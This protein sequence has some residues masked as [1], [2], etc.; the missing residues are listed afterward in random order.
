MGG[1]FYLKKNICWKLLFLFVSQ[2]NQN[3]TKGFLQLKIKPWQRVLLTRS[4][5]I[6]PAVLVSLVIKIYV[7]ILLKI[8]VSWWQ[9]ASS[10]LGRLDNA[11]NVCQSL[12][13]PFAVLPVLK[14]TADKNVIFFLLLWNKQ[15]YFDWIYSNFLQHISRLWEILPI[16]K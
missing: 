14:F 15:F 13:L 7:W 3:K 2:L 10:D 6:V 4:L 16:I 8:N 11:M 9:L 12:L 5:A 1:D